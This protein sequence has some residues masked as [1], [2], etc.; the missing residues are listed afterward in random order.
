MDF[1]NLVYYICAKQL[2]KVALIFKTMRKGEFKIIISVMNANN[3]TYFN[4][5][6]FTNRDDLRIY[7]VDYVSSLIRYDDYTL[8]G[9]S[10]SENYCVNLLYNGNCRILIISSSFQT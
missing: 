2:I 3:I 8:C 7:H 10:K 1:D 9:Y 6:S 4:E 5:I